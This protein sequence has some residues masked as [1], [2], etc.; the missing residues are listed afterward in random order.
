MIKNQLVIK[1]YLMIV[2]FH[3]KLKNEIYVPIDPMWA[4]AIAPLWALDY[5]QCFELA[6]MIDDPLQ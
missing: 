4:L 6:A 2:D 3:Y 5:L 1:D